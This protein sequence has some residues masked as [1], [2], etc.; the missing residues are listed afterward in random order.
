MIRQVETLR[1]KFH[2]FRLADRKLLSNRGVEVDDAR[3]DDRVSRGVAVT[4]L[5][6][7]RKPVHECIGVEKMSSGSLASR[8]VR[9]G[10]CRIGI[11]CS[12]TILN[13]S[14]TTQYGKRKTILQSEDAAELPTAQ[15][16]IGAAKRQV[17]QPGGGQAAPEIE[18]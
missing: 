14:G 11:T 10:S 9:I 15:Q 17:P 3:T 13:G 12:T 2:V 8:K 4:V 5:R 6:S 18:S 16:L 7:K 1:S